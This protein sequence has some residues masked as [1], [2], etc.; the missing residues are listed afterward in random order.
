MGCFECGCSSIAER[1][2]HHKPTSLVNQLVNSSW[3]VNQLVKQ[4]LLVNWLVNWLNWLVNWLVNSLLASLRMRPCKYHAALGQEGNH[5]DADCTS[6]EAKAA[7]ESQQAGRQA[8]SGNLGVDLG[9]DS[10]DEADFNELPHEALRAIGHGFFSSVAGMA[11]TAVP[12]PVLGVAH[13]AEPSRRAPSAFPPR[14]SPPA[15]ALPPR[16]ELAA[17]SDRQ[18]RSIYLACRAYEQDHG[19][20]NG[21]AT[22]RMLRASDAGVAGWIEI[23]ASRSDNFVL[24][25][26]LWPATTTSPVSIDGAH[27][28]IRLTGDVPCPIYY[29]GT[30]GAAGIYCGTF[31]AP[32]NLNVRY[33]SGRSMRPGA[34]PPSKACKT[35][36]AA[37]EMC[38]LYDHPPVFRGP[39]SGFGLPVGCNLVTGSLDVPVGVPS[40]SPPGS[41]ATRADSAR[42]DSEPDYD[43]CH[44]TDCRNEAAGG[45]CG[46]F[47]CPTHLVLAGVGGRAAVRQGDTCRRPNCSR[48]V[49]LH[50]T[51]PLTGRVED[52]CGRGCRDLFMATHNPPDAVGVAAADAAD[53]CIPVVSAAAC[54]PVSAHASA[55]P[56][57]IT[58]SIHAI[59]R[60]VDAKLSA[61]R[62]R[63][64][65]NLEAA[66]AAGDA[67]P[68]GAMP[69]AAHAKPHALYLSVILNIVMAVAAAAIAFAYAAAKEAGATSLL[70]RAWLLGSLGVVTV[71]AWQLAIAC[72]H[73][74]RRLCQAKRLCR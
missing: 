65:V 68:L 57:A 19:L 4:N 53:S 36:A 70:E 16:N 29:I 24:D 61:A 30:G 51:G 69:A 2:H 49:W 38:M 3:L 63:Q 66:L 46:Q 48:D 44:L 9:I 35:F 58:D 39:R 59:A 28:T 43:R 71:G 11:Q 14:A 5:L 72:L 17:A 42:S 37:I 22:I 23:G 45:H 6:A 74:T 20:G 26:T 12:A 73:G 41:D 67:Q 32:D 56:D 13:M 54:A 34:G 25:P 15:S 27:H 7:Y 50:L 8:G 62:T 10:G 18:A 40:A 55:P 47:C 21:E 33:V 60:N 31:D 52:F 1:R 64:T